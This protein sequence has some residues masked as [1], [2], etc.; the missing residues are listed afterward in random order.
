MGCLRWRCRT[1]RRES[2]TLWLSSN[3]IGGY[4]K[5]TKIHAP[6]DTGPTLQPEMAFPTPQHLSR[7]TVLDRTSPH[8]VRPSDR[9]TVSCSNHPFKDL[10]NV[11]VGFS[12]REIKSCPTH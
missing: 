9:V 11:V 12:F 3:D 7:L 4:K 6:A 2:S 10:R 5:Q 1:G 8:W